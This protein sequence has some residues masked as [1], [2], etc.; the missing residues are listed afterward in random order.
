MSLYRIIC[1]EYILIYSELP[2]SLMRSS[3]QPA[4]NSR[5]ETLEYV[6][7]TTKQIVLRYFIIL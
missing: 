3:I 6:Q 4:I 1:P 2:E 7:D 5:F